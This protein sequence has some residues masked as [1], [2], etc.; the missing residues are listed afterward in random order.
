[1]ADGSKRFGVLE[2]VPSDVPAAAG[3]QQQLADARRERARGRMKYIGELY[4]SLRAVLSGNFSTRG[5]LSK[6]AVLQATIT[7]IRSLS[8]ELKRIKSDLQPP[9]PHAGLEDYVSADVETSISP[10]EWIVEV[11][12]ILL[13]IY[14]MQPPLFLP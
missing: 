10:N 3:W 11:L 5:K 8:F 9:P 6:V 1:M 12:Y 4:Y 2:P 7:Y 13:K 14:A